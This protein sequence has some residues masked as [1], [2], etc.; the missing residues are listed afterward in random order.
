MTVRSTSARFVGRDQELAL[1]AR[2]LESAAGGRTTTLLLAG[3]AGIGVSRLLDESQRRLA[4]LPDPFR[5]I[6]ARP[7]AG[8]TGEPYAQVVAAF[9]PAFARLPDDALAA[10][11]GPGAEALGPLFPELRE[12]FDSLGL[13]PARPWLVSRERRQPRLLEAILGVLERLGERAPVVLM[14]EDLHAADGATRALVTFLARVTRPGRVCVIGTYQPDVL[15]WDHPLGADLAAMAEATR[16]PQRLELGPLDRDALADLVAGV[17]DERPAAAVLLLVAERSAG[18]PLIAEELLLARRELSGVTVAGSFEQLVVARLAQRSPEC[19]RVLRLLAAAREPLTVAELAA[20]SEAFE[21]LAEGPPPRSSGAPRKAGDTLDGDL[22]AGLAEAIEHAY[23]VPGPGS[24]V[25]PAAQ[26]EAISTVP[27]STVPVSTAAASLTP[28]TLLPIRHELVARGI[29]SDLLPAHRRRLHAALGAAMV[30][31]PTARVHHLLAAHDVAAAGAAA[32]EAADRAASLDAPSD[33]LRAL[34][35][36]IELEPPAAGRDARRASAE[37]L[38]RAA[39]AAFA[40]DLPGRAV[41]F[42]EAAIARLDERADRHELGRLH[43]RLGRFRRV[44]GDQRGSLTAHHRAVDLVPADAGRE[45]ALVLAGLAQ[46]LML[47]GQFAE[48][49]RTAAEAI[50]TARRAGGD[51]RAEEGHALCTLGIARAWGDDAEEAPALLDE[52][53]AIAQEMGRLDDVF[54]AIAN[55]TT[56][57]DLL[58]RRDA[59]IAAARD[60][61]DRA[62]A[63]GLD[64]VY[65]NFIRGNVANILFLAGRWDEAREMSRTALEWSPSGPVVLDA[66]ASLAT[67]EIES[68]ADEA[69]ARMLGRLLLALETRPD[70]QDVGPAS[71]AAASFALW[72]GDVVDAGRT[73]ELGWSQAIQTEDWVLISTMAATM[74]EVL[75]ATVDDGRERRDLAG[76]AGAR[77]RAVEVIETA[78]AA[79]RRGATTPT[80][81]SRRRA[82]ASLATARAYKARMD[83]RGEPGIWDSLAQL[84]ERAGEPYQVA[85]AR[86]RQAQAALTAN[87]ARTGRRIAGAPL[88]EAVRVARTLDARPLLRELEELAERALIALPEVAPVSLGAT[89]PDGS[90]VPIPIGAGANGGPGSGEGGGPDEGGAARIV[91]PS[92]GLASAFVGPPAPKRGHMFGLSARER[93]V[94]ALMAEGRTNREIGERLFISQKTVGVHVGNVLAKMRVSGRVEAATAAIRLGLTEG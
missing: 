94:L 10:V 48:S 33:E 71:R 8:R 57:L 89:I 5:V 16:M 61:I 78:E 53:R 76:V 82:E 70:P 1:L 66:E 34:E 22:T 54:R 68:V 83:G 32:L 75:A 46:G 52:A 2:T 35:L 73:A 91:L 24:S 45:R 21:A 80:L 87:D 79:V 69:A 50:A 7:G 81:G 23:V 77:A 67:V 9:R 51:A 11:V 17:E 72:R 92:G 26:T 31:R 59:A 3:T 90:L 86:W 56:A 4:G 41:A 49:E 60:G 38:M 6:R 42:S 44:M 88:R 65:G 30:D 13:L 84:W 25:A 28:D 12:R 43:D 36:A 47:D 39:E 74:L 62:R 55:L 29:A 20:A 64:A 19:R 27:V 40:A 37:L 15:T 58:G 14:L 93:E 63:V 85:R 18:N